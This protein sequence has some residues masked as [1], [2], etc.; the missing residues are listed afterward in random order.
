MLYDW[1][2]GERIKEMKTIWKYKLSFDNP[3]VCKIEMP[4][5]AKILTVQPQ[6][7]HYTLWALV[8][9]SLPKEVRQFIIQ[10]TGW[11]FD[12]IDLEYISTH[13][14]GGF[15]WHIFEKV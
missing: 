1:E 12:D 15:V 2:T 9:P 13:Q 6:N 7:E 14:V 11:E 4:R 10:G 3:D 8:N 5:I